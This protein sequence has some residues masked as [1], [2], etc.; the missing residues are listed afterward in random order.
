MPMY[1]RRRRAFVGWALLALAQSGCA[2]PSGSQPAQEPTSTAVRLGTRPVRC[3]AH[4]C[5]HRVMVPTPWF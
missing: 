2:D 3:M 1:S 4:W 5:F